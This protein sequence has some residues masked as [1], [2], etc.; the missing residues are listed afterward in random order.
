MEFS[1]TTFAVIA[2]GLVGVLRPIFKAVEVV[3][4]DQVKKQVKL[5]FVL[6]GMVSEVTTVVNVVVL[7]V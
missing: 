5:A 7:L 4:P 1:M 2:V 3:E 6:A